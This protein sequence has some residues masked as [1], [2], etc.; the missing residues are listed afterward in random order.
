MKDYE[1][2]NDLGWGICK[3]YLEIQGVAFPHIT[4]R[5]MLKEVVAKKL[6]TQGQDCNEALYTHNAMRRIY[7]L[8][9]FRQTIGAKGNFDYFIGI[10]A[11]N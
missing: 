6:I 3:N 5:D 8:K 11:I 9:T 1:K 4:P 10:I 7:N 2:S